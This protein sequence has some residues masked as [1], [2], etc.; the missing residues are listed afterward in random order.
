MRKNSTRQCQS[1]NENWNKSLTPPAYNLYERPKSIT[2]TT[3]NVG[4]DMEQQECAFITGRSGKPCDTLEN[5]VLGPYGIKHILTT[6][7]S[8]NR[9]QC[10]PNK[11]KNVWPHKHLRMD[12]YGNLIHNHNLETSWCPLTLGKIGINKLVHL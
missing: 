1:G 12:V 5:S 3:P 9:P 4:K 6:W 8:S 2:P 10:S 11:L 7:A